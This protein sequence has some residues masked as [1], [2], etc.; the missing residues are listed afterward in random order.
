M[1]QLDIHSE[2]NSASQSNKKKRATLRHL[3]ALDIDEDGLFTLRGSLRDTHIPLPTTS[4]KTKVHESSEPHIVTSITNNFT[5][6]QV[7]IIPFVPE[8]YH[9][10]V[11]LIC[12]NWQ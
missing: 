4:P 6:I 7:P 3:E 9:R 11:Y 12:S 2:L 5:P 8:K 1:S 10:M